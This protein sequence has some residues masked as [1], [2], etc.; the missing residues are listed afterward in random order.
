MKFDRNNKFD[1][2]YYGQVNSIWLSTLGRGNI[3]FA[4]NGMAEA[5]P[6]D[7]GH[8][9]F[10]RYEPAGVVAAITPWNFPLMLETWKIAPALAWGNTVVLKPAEDSP[11]SATIL[12]RLATQAGFPDGVLNVVHGFGPDSAGAYLT[13]HPGTDRITFTGESNTGRVITKVA[14]ERLVP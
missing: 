4:G 2:S 6:M 3:Y 9:A 8:H 14:A 1:L 7:S 13:Q 10:C 11:A 5:Y 12:A